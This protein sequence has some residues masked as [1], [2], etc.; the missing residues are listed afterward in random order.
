MSES[1]STAVRQPTALPDPAAGREPTSVQAAKTPVGTPGVGLLGILFALI[2]VGLG[3]VMI[4]DAVVYAGW[5]SGT[6][7]LQ[8]LANRLGNT[9][10][11]SG[12]LAWSIVVAVVGLVV[13]AFAL[14]RRPRPP[15]RLTGEV[16]MFLTARD[17]GRIAGAAAESVGGVLDAKAR[18]GRRKVRVA[19]TTTAHSPNSGID[20]TVA[21]E[22]DRRLSVLTRPPRVTIDVEGGEQ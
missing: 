10:A 21:Q 9:H 13:L 11:D 15:Y 18:A 12:V 20:G 16:P 7:W 3:V 19:I 14:G 4:R 6:P 1:S 8:G 2:T 5:T 17:V 22:V